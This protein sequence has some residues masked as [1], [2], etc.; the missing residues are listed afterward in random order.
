[1][2]QLTPLLLESLVTVAAMGKLAPGF[3]DWVVE[4]FNVMVIE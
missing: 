2:F 3:R 1:V 4:G